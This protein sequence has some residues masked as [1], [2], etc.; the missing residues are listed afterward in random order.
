MIRFIWR[1]HKFASRIVLHIEAHDRM[2][3]GLNAAVCGARME[4]NRSINTP[5][6][7]NRP[8]C[9][10]CLRSCLDMEKGIAA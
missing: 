1:A 9:R 3:R 5:F 2:G 8:V 6:N 4:F 10:N 7:L